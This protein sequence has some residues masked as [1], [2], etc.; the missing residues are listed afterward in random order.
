[1]PLQFPDFQ[2]ISFDEANPMLTGMAKGQ[3]LMQ[4]NLKFPIDLQSAIL[5]NKLKGQEFDWNPRIWESEIGLRGAQSGLAGAQTGLTQS[6]TGMSNLKL[7][8]LQQVLSG[9]QPSGGGGGGS[10]GGGADSGYSYDSQGR[11]VVASPDEVSQI[12]QGGNAGM[13]GGGQPSQQPSGGQQQQA[14]QG[15]SF[16]GVDVP[17]PSQSDIANSMLL[18][19]DTFGPKRD[20]AKSQI[21]DQYTQYQKGIQDAIQ[22]AN[23][24]TNLSQ[25]MSVFNNAMDKSFYRGQ[26]LGHVPSDGYLSP[27]GDLSPEQEADRAALQ[28]MPAAIETLKGAMGSARFS[29]LDMNMATKMKFDR[30]MNDETRQVQSQWVNGVNNRMQEKSK[31]M[32]TMGNPRSGAMKSDADQLWT[33]YQ[34]DFPLISKDGKTFQGSNL[35]NWPL[36]TTPRAIASIRTKGTYS[37]TAAEK[38]VFMMQVPDGRGGY[39]VMPV[40]KGKVESAFRKGAKPL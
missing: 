26:R 13:Q 39:Q 23:A 4:N 8:Y 27:P 15:N 12:S 34:Q 30:T 5:A 18:G 35:N 3:Q 38:N 28:M 22:E 1:M 9:G 31:F 19:I 33:Q 40:K 25:A 24:A 2:R 11:N 7:R 21:Q 37:P 14:P 32:Q 17:Q 36:Y 16:Y 6:Q 20:N 29:N 10:V